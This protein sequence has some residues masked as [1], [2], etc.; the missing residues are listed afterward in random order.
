MLPGSSILCA[1]AAT[2]ISGL[3]TDIAGRPSC[4]ASTQSTFFMV[5]RRRCMPGGGKVKIQC[6]DLKGTPG[7]R[8]RVSTLA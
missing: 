4:T 6:T 3:L 1:L 7:N 2:L 5:W 8:G